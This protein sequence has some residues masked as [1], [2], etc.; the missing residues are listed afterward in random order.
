MLRIGSPEDARQLELL[1]C[2]LGTPRSGH[3][4]YAAAMYFYIHGMID[5][6][7]LEVYRICSPLDHD[8]PM[9]ILQAQGLAYEVRPADATNGAA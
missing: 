5:G 3:T 6:D 8:D 1:N 4:R 2:A 7:T 9:K